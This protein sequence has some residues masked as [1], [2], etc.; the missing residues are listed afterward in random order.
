[1][2]GT[3]L[4]IATVLLG[5]T[6]GVLLGG[7]LPE[8]LRQTVIAGLGLFTA[9]MGLQMFL[10]TKNAMIVLGSILVG[11]LLGEWMHIEEGL[12]GLGGLLERKFNRSGG[13]GASSD[14]FIHAFITASLVFC[15]GPMAILGSIK[16][17]LTGDFSLLAVKSI[18]DGFAA[19]AFASSM[20]VGVLFSTIIILVYQGGLTL[21]AAQAQAVATTAMI[22]E[23]NAAGG[24]ML[25]GIAVSS[26][27]EIKKIRVASFLPALVIAPL[28][29][30]AL[31]ALGI[32][33]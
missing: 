7:R 9:A 32:K 31:T 14:R 26:L 20:G 18:L 33:Y 28:I 5:G 19:L 6:L 4:N 10:T 24:I 25:M 12:A 16:D 29:V 13:D 23:M 17:G 21:L 22:A 1:M 15:V 2:R 11:A 30:W 3:L 8:K 27:L